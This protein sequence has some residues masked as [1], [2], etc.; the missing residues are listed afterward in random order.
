[1]LSEEEKEK[2]MQNNSSARAIAKTLHCNIYAF[3]P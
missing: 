1:M 2:K 3:T